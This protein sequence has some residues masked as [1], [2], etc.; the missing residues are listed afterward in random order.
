LIKKKNKSVGDMKIIE[1]VGIPGAGKSTLAVRYKEDLK[2]R[3]VCF[4]ESRI[5]K[6]PKIIRRTLKI[7]RAIHIMCSPLY[8]KLNFNL[9]C[10]TMQYPFSMKRLHRC[11]LITELFVQLKKDIKNNQQIVLEEGLVQF[12]TS[13][14]HLEPLIQSKALKALLVELAPVLLETTY[15]DC[16]INY[17]IAIY[18]T[19]QRG[20]MRNRFDR[21]PEN[22]RLPAFEVKRANIDKVFKAIKELDIERRVIMINTESAPDKVYNELCVQ[23]KNT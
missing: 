6:H 17:G 18:R 13:I 11:Y 1:F 7:I 2:K 14:M 19:S 12:I 5:N 15:I 23:L 4:K 16:Q 3:G 8:W 20:S 22:L 10:I 9:L 21:M